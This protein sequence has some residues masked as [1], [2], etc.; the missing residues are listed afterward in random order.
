[1]EKNNVI[2]TFLKYLF[3]IKEFNQNINFATI[4]TLQNND[5][6][7]DKIQKYIKTNNKLFNPIIEENQNIITIDLQ[8]NDLK[9]DIKFNKDNKLLFILKEKDKKVKEFDNY[10]NLFISIINNNLKEYD[11]NTNKKMK[12]IF[13]LK[14]EIENMILKS[15]KNNKQQENNLKF[16]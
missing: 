16:G 15:F 12:A 10:D 4:E 11:K 2:E 14:Y 8:L 1:M 6:F 3:N 9:I 7:I 5:K 13:I